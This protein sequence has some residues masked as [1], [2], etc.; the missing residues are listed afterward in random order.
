MPRFTSGTG[1]Q[2]DLALTKT[3]SPEP[4]IA[5]DLVSYTLT[6]TNRGP[7]AAAAVTLTR[8]AAR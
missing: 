6:V 5:G 8:H 7:S 2:A 3:A 4:A 1:V